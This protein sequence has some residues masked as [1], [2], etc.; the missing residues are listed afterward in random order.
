MN[1]F[2]VLT[3]LYTNS[4]SKWILSLDDNDIQPF[5]IQKWLIMNDNLRTQVR[6]LDKYVFNLPPKMYLSL[7][8]SLIFPKFKQMPFNKY[9]KKIDNEEEEF[10][11]ITDV[12]RKQYELSDNDFRANKNLIIK[13]IKSNMPFWFRVYGV[14]KFYWKKYYLNFDDIKFDDK[15]VIGKNDLK[16]WG[17]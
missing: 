7:V 10:K 17:F 13:E 16:K 14:Q 12:I 11:F 2:E 3:N 1:I 8:W 4:S 6:W 5:L 15:K 9:I